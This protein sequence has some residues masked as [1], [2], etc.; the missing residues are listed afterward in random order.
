LVVFPS[1]FGLSAFRRYEE[2]RR[3]KTKVLPLLFSDEIGE[4]TAL[5]KTVTFAFIGSTADV[6]N[7]NEYCR[8]IHYHHLHDLDATFAITT[9]NRIDEITLSNL[10]P[11]LRKGVLTIR[12]G[13]ILTNAEINSAYA[14]AK[15]V[16]LMYTRSNQS[17][18]LGKSLMFGCGVV[19]SAIGSFPEYVEPSF[20]ILL[21]YE[22]CR[23]RPQVL[24]DGLQSLIKKDLV[25]AARCAYAKNF[26]ASCANGD[27]AE[28]IMARE[29]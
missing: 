12:H 5:K 26:E 16:W 20:G 4:D 29:G 22:S 15:I 1:Q 18:V 3:V 10:A 19:A 27:C 6:H 28:A 23:K 24:F 2:I 9:R 25:S 8:Y 14:E 17:G 21:D 13:K 11:L 7:F